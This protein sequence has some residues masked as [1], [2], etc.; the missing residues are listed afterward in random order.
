LCLHQDINL[1][2]SY[3]HYYTHPTP[4]GRVTHQLA[5]IDLVVVVF[6]LVSDHIDIVQAY[7]CHV[8][9]GDRVV[10]LFIPTGKECIRLKTQQSMASRSEV[11]KW[12]AKTTLAEFETPLNSDFRF[13]FQF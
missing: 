5:L 9:S 1:N 3:T 10:V 13:S 7:H 6:V 12:N 11:I 4:L 8:V 2:L